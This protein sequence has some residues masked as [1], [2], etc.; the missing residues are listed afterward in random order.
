MAGDINQLRETPPTAY[1]AGTP[2]GEDAGCAQVVRLDDETATC[3]DLTG[4][5][6][7]S[8]ARAAV[9]GLLVVPGFV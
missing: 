5:K 4:T 9:A 1:A 3:V 8:L 2:S 7:A 6:A